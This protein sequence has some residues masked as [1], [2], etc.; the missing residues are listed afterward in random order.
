MTKRDIII[1]I[2]K[3]EKS[4]FGYWFLVIALSTFLVYAIPQKYDAV[5]KILIEGN[6][7]PVMRADVAFGV[8]QMSALNSSVAIIRS[9]PVLA[10]T[11]EEIAAIN[12]V[13]KKSADAE[14]Q[15]GSFAK[16]LDEIGQWML[17]VGLRDASSPRDQLINDLENGIKVAPEPNSNIIAISYRSTDPRMAATIVNSLTDNYIKQ[18]LKLYSSVGTSEVYRLQI[19]RLEKDLDM[20]RKELSEYKRD[21]AVSAL[22]ETRRA[23]VQQQ[24]QLTSELARLESALAEL[25]TRFDTGHT[26]V[27]LVEER[28]RATRQGLADIAKTLL[29]LE[30][31]ESAIRKMEIE[32]N[33]AGLTLQS[34]K[35][36]FQDEQMVQLANPDVVNVLIVEKAVPPSRPLH[37]R[38]F[39]ILL[40]TFG[41]LLL[42]FAIAF[43]KEYFDHRV[44][45]PK[46]ASQLLGVPTLG[47]IE[48]A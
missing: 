3:W 12:K 37:S 47:S 36:L 9:K 33:A 19:E 8:E 45:D 1:F 42:S 39:Y 28:L 21:N 41:G 26:K 2:F 32:I 23:Q 48:K 20:R 29:A 4:L 35:K 34:Y 10:A 5:A 25:K 30:T 24:A 11:A 22:T 46:V 15:K 7:A 6:R 13:N 18:H 17:D 43:I 31:E 27:I 44:N 40:A 16:L 38:L 14:A